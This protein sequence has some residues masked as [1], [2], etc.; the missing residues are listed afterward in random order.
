VTLAGLIDRVK[1]V[2]DSAPG[3]RPDTVMLNPRD[4]TAFAIDSG[5]AVIDRRGVAS[6][7]VLAPSGQIIVLP[8][9]TIELGADAVIYSD[10]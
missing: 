6:I 3:R 1:Q 4:F 2:A 5:A 8:D 7:V 9:E 10:S